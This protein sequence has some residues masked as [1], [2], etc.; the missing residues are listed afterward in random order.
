[1]TTLN[2]LAGRC[3]GAKAADR[4]L[5]GFIHANVTGEFTHATARERIA[6]GGIMTDGWEVLKNGEVWPLPRYTASLDAA[7]TLVPE[8]LSVKLYAHPGESHA[9]VYSLHPSKGLLGEGEQAATPALALCAAA[10][11]ARQH[12]LSVAQEG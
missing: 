7:M 11:R 9:D 2:E 10:L 1:M 5:D 4:T 12:L 6:M 8:G 3:E